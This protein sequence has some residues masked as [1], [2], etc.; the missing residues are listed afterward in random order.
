[1]TFTPRIREFGDAA[2]FVELDEGFTEPTAEWARAIAHFWDL[3]PALPAY[4]SVVVSF[5]PERMEADV[6]ERKLRDLVARGPMHVVEADPRAPHEPLVRVV[7][8]PT[9]YD[10]EDLEDV[11]RLSKLSVDEVVAIHSGREYTAIFLGFLPGWAY[12]ARLDPRIVATRLPSPRPRIAAGSVAVVDGQTGVYPFVC[13]GGWR[14]IGSTDAVMF[15]PKRTPA[16]LIGAGDRVR[17][18]PT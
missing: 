3:G 17:F 14:L 11:A 4:A 7:E 18:V 13:P 1:V 10:G 15:D 9:R 16:S 5:D 12:C 6:A 2:L 8:I